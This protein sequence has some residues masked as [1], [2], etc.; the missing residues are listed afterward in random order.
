MFSSV[1]RPLVLLI[2]FPIHLLML[3]FE[4]ILGLK[5]WRLYKKGPSNNIKPLG[6][7]SNFAKLFYY[8]LY[9]DTFCIKL[10]SLFTSEQHGFVKNRST[11]TNLLEISQ[12][13]I[14]MLEEIQGCWNASRYCLR[15]HSIPQTT[16]YCFLNLLRWV[17]VMF[18]ITVSFV[19]GSNL[20]YI[21][22]EDEMLSIA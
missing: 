9:N 17:F 10:N 20:K 15:R 2:P 16:P 6:I 13:I 18:L 11:A 3:V 4:L 7:L 5:L 14:W 12:V 19:R 21:I 8:M 22:A 1:F